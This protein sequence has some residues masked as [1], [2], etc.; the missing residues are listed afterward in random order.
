MA[1]FRARQGRYYMSL[2]HIMPEIKEVLKVDD[3]LCHKDRN[4]LE[5]AVGQISDNLR[6]E[7]QRKPWVQT[8]NK[9]INN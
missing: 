5:R 2:E 1:D 7:V 8:N 9:Q 6:T 4:L 3:G